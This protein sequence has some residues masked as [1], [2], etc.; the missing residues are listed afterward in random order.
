MSFNNTTCGCCTGIKKS[1]PAATD[2]RPGLN[3]LHYRVGDYAT[4]LETML[5]RLST[6]CLGTEQ[7]CKT[8]LGTYPL[9]K[10]SSRTADDFAIA[11]LHGWATVADVLTFYQERL[12]NEGYLRTATERRSVLEL[13]RLIGYQPRPGV[14]ASVFLGY[15][16]DDKLKEQALIGKGTRAQSIPGPGELPQSFET[17]EDLQA[18]AAWNNL[19]PRMSRPQTVYSLFLDVKGPRIYLSGIDTKLKVNDPLLVDVMGDN[20][21][22]LFRV[23]EVVADAL[24]NRTLV[25]LQ[26]K[27]Q[28]FDAS[29]DVLDILTRHKNIEFILLDSGDG[30]PG[31]FSFAFN[32]DGSTK[33]YS[34]SDGNEWSFTHTANGAQFIEL[35]RG[36]EHLVYEVKAIEI[37]DGISLTYLRL[38]LQGAQFY[39]SMLTALNTRPSL[40]PR[41]ATRLHRG[42]TE[43]F[44]GVPT[45]QD[46]DGE[47]PV[48]RSIS[49]GAKTASASF[50]IKGLSTIAE[51]SNAVVKR[52]APMLHD[53]LAI[54]TSNAGITET[55][56]IK[57]YALRAKATPFG[58]NAPLRPTSF[59]RDKGVY[60]VAE[61]LITDPYNEQ[62]SITAEDYHKPKV[63]YL[64]ADYDITPD[65]WIV[66]EN[67]SLRT[68]RIMR[69]DE[70][71]IQHKALAAYGISGKT[72]Q[73]NLQQVWIRS[74][75]PF[76]TVRDTTVYIQSEELELAEEPVST[77]ICG[78]VDDL[79]EL[80]DYYEA[81]EAGRWVI[82][83]GERDDIPG[84]TG[85]RFSELAMLSVVQQD[86][87]RQT[88]HLHPG[89][90][91]YT[92]PGDKIHSF[93][94][95]AKP[96]A[97]CFKRDTI[98]IYGN[99]VK[100][101]HG[102]TRQEVLGSGNGAKALQ[103]FT[104]KQPP[105]T[106]VPAA[107]P[108]GADSTLKVWVN[109]VEWHQSK[110]LN[111]LTATG[112]S[113]ISKTDDEG[114]TTVIFGNGHQGARLPTGIEN[115]KAEYRNGIGK[116]GNV[117]AEQ[118]SLL[119]SRPLG[120]KEVINPL[121][122]SGGADKESRDQARKNAPLTVAALDRLVSVQDYQ[123][124]S[125]TYAGIGKACAT[126]LSDGRRQIVHVTIAGADDVP[127]DESSD[128]FLN[129]RQ[130]LHDFGDPFQPIQL[131]VREL[132]LL[133]ISA[134]IKINADYQ[135]ERVVVSLRTALLKAL[136]FEQRELG[137]NV[138][139][140]EIIGVMQGVPGVDYIDI[141]AFGGLPE[142]E[143]VSGQRRPLTPGQIAERVQQIAEQESLKPYLPVNLAKSE[144]G[145]I[146]PAQMAF[147]S[148]DVPESLILNQIL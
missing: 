67:K 41:N 30:L 100:A 128:L 107:N 135:W 119:V 34:I 74:E 97:Y 51:G 31:F 1:T 146:R 147:L 104:L 11:L 148:P 103:A 87:N 29:R 60:N 2:N 144:G 108:S 106:F 55:N 134:K 57:V 137:Q 63:L 145:V 127:I 27:H 54:A 142:K 79:I 113:F 112:R 18:R 78:G 124:F 15:T 23:K 43:Q 65:S 88:I 38:T 93:I 109:G 4:F 35:S 66:I 58:Y 25:M 77:P 138:M 120:V 133:V 114:K 129:L 5:A 95:L 22:I 83:T 132:M 20:N 86:I 82:V 111:T 85:V 47:A 94:Q 53:N 48:F 50:L 46:D 117:K 75:E 8:G 141:E 36:D 81:L 37:I 73:L 16:L 9:Q 59:N 42:L 101:T 122:A 6:L 72:T 40:Q 76:S 89:K 26:T 102:E 105:L 19:K 17:S 90:R 110:S 96:L 71:H 64:D 45:V 118:I 70:D 13:A 131:A 21:P 69:V 136:G 68:Q 130:A 49:A 3:S 115:I 99:V 98:K 32:V 28:Q 84:T 139:L 126:E 140:S 123:D 7:D 80:E 24:G 62:S 125:R 33:L 61:W 12:I 143:L 91:R 44:L 92:L 116:A 56:P 14:S 52:F 121:R 39:S 10:L